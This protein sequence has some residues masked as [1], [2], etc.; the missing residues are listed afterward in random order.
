VRITA[1]CEHGERSLDVE[2]SPVL[3]LIGYRALARDLLLACPR[4]QF[5]ARG[6]LESESP[7][8]RDVL[9]GVPGHG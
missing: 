7:A 5:D 4:C 2:P 6:F 9:P 3:S 8:I 1:K